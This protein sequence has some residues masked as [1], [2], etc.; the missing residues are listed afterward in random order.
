M[1]MK[2]VSKTFLVLLIA[3]TTT[4]FTAQRKPKLVRKPIQMEVESDVSGIAPEYNPLKAEQSFDIGKYYFKKKSW[5]AATKR[6]QEAL[7]YKPDYPDAQKWLVRS[8]EKLAQSIEKLN[9]KQQK[10]RY[11]ETV[12]LLLEFERKYPD[13]ASIEK[14]RKAR[15]HIEGQISTTVP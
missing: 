5:V 1:L 3:S 4:L 2:Q 15:Q 6:F 7:A 10:K 9:P 8:L 12:I 13:S 14:L 11:E